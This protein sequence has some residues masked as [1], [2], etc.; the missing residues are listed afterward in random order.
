MVASRIHNT[1]GTR[2]RCK[3]LGSYDLRGS[4]HKILVSIDS[5]NIVEK[6]EGE[7]RISSRLLLVL[8]SIS[9]AEIF[10]ILV[11]I[12]MSLVVKLYRQSKSLHCSMEN[13]T[14]AFRMLLQNQ[15]YFRGRP[16]IAASID[17]V[18]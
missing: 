7:M 18:R 3:K 2:I 11:V 13:F 9:V 16:I 8:K 1:M 17:H 4:R 5:Q 6:I 15:E 10:L 14:L 12:G